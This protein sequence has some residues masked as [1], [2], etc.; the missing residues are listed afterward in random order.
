MHVNLRD[1]SFPSQGALS[2]LLP[3]LPKPPS[4][5]HP[6]GQRLDESARWELLL[7]LQAVP[8]LRHT[9]DWGAPTWPVKGA[10][11][12]GHNKKEAVGVL[13]PL[14][15]VLSSCASGFAHTHWVLRDCHSLPPAW[16]EGLTRHTA[17]LLPTQ[18]PAGLVSLQCRRAQSCM[19]TLRALVGQTALHAATELSS[20][21]LSCQNL[22]SYQPDMAS[23]DL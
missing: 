1:V 14:D 16:T 2:L 23:D 3:P 21:S 5:V 18:T 6:T 12:L 11:S 22:S 17:P 8:M 15:L 9:K 10:N 13:A 19:A 20:L 4:S 7:R